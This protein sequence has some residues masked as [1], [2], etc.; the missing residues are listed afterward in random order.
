[1]SQALFRS[2]ESREGST[3]FLLPWSLILMGSTSKIMS[4]DKSTIFSLFFLLP[5]EAPLVW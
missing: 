3:G 1:M 4:K 5:T 2:L